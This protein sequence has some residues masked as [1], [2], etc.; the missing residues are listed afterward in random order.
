MKS[1]ISVAKT[2]DHLVMVA[3]TVFNS[4][5]LIVNSWKYSTARFLL[6]VAIFSIWNPRYLKN[7]CTFIFFSKMKIDHRSAPG[8]RLIKAFSAY[9]YTKPT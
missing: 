9:K 8:C 3:T 7:L 2:V 5:F 4:F 6:S 1:V